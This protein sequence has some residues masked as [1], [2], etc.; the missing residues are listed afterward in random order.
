MATLPRR[1]LDDLASL[2]G[3]EADHARPDEGREAAVTEALRSMPQ[4][5]RPDPRFAA[6]LRETLLRQAGETGERGP[7]AVPTP[8]RPE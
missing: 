1:D 7:A 8:V 5:V 6:H 3:E 2:V 4:E